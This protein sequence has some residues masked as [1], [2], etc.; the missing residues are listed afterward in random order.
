MSSERRHQSVAAAGPQAAPTSLSSAKRSRKRM[1]ACGDLPREICEQYL[2]SLLHGAR[3]DKLAM[4][5]VARQN[6]AIFQCMEERG[7]ASCGKCAEGMAG[8][9]FHGQLDRICPAGVSSALGRALPWMAQRVM[10]G[11]VATSGGKSHSWLT[12]TRSPVRPSAAT[13]SVAAGRSETTRMSGRIA[14][15]HRRGMARRRW[16]R[17][18]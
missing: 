17:R 14:R 8:C 9:V 1:A 3:S 16:R 7:L 10:R 13:I 2:S 12:A 18:R 5:R 11:L 15:G 6:C 4:R